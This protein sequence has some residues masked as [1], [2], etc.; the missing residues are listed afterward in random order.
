MG[1]ADIKRLAELL[2][3]TYEARSIVE[4]WET[5]ESCRVPFSKLPG[6]DDVEVAA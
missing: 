2:H 4:G 3:A 5:Q 6:P 1:D